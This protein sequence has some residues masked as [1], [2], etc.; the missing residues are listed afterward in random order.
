[1]PDNATYSLTGT[2]ISMTYTTGAG[3]LEFTLDDSFRPFDG[4]HNLTS[5]DLKQHALDPGVQITG[6]LQHTSVGRGGPRVETTNFSVFLADAPE[7]A[8]SA[9]E[10]SATGV[11]VF[12]DPSPSSGLTPEYSATELTGSLSV[13]SSH[14]GRF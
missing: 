13:P 6:S 1:M 7:P 11:A 5:A 14:P 10:Y 8:E 9:A 3:D 12:A 4:T 2:G